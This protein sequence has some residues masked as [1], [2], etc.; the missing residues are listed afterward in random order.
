ML[1]YFDQPDATAEAIDDLGLLHTG[2]VGRFLDDGSLEVVGRR[3]DLVIRGGANVYPAEV[4]R[5]LSQHADV[6]EA[7]VLGLP[8]E[9]LGEIVVAAVRLRAGAAQDEGSL[10]ALLGEHLARYKVPSR[11]VFVDDFPRNP[12]GKIAKPALR[13]MVE[14]LP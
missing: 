7:C 3:N 9:R 1:G 6:A 11:F 12:M 14:G 13:R 4:E 10:R 2:D 8:D 5:V